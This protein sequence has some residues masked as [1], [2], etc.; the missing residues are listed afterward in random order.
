MCH[1]PSHWDTPPPPPVTARSDRH[2]KACWAEWCF[3]KMEGGT[4]VAQRGSNGV[5]YLLF[6]GGEGIQN[7]KILLSTSWPR[8][9]NLVS[10]TCFG[11][12]NKWGWQMWPHIVNEFGWDSDGVQYRRETNIWKRPTF[13]WSWCVSNCR[14]QSLTSASPTTMPTGLFCKSYGYKDLPSAFLSWPKHTRV[15]TK[16]FTCLPGEKPVYSALYLW[17]DFWAMQAFVFWA[18]HVF[19]W[20][21]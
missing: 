8:N 6:R 18:S 9:E 10:C 13:Q 21:L 20:L 5:E 15:P 11:G 1:T 2:H 16:Y 3:L 7:L 19:S 17:Q 4:L 12:T 14:S